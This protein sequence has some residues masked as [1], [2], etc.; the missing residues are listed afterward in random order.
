MLDVVVEWV[1]KRTTNLATQLQLNF[2]HV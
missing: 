2:E 1:Q